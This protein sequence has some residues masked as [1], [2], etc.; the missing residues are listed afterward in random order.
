MAQLLAVFGKQAL[1]T[2]LLL[3][4]T[5][6]LMDSLSERELEVLRLLADRLVIAVETARKHIEN[7][8]SK[9][10]AH[11]RWEAIKRA[12]EIALL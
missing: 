6:V 9:L 7:I 8:Y 12:E 3:S 5:S 1:S 4:N 10:D 11:S 2:A